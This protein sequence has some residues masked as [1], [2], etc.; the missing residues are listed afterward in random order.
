MLI[1][2]LLKNKKR[3]LVV[4]SLIVLRDFILFVHRARRAIRV[5]LYLRDVTLHLN[6]ELETALPL[7]KV[8]ISPA[9]V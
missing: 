9:A 8:N 3:V 2:L 4:A 6:Q 5:F 7:T 1:N